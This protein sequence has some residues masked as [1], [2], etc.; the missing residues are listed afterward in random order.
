[1]TEKRSRAE[2]LCMDGTIAS[3][4]VPVFPHNPPV[5][6]WKGQYFTGG[7]R[8]HTNPAVVEYMEVDTY[9]VPSAGMDSADTEEMRDHLL[10]RVEELEEENDRL[11]PLGD[12]A[13]SYLQCYDC[14]EAD[15]EFCWHHDR[16]FTAALKALSGQQ[17]EF[18]EVE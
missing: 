7:D 17:I 11:R 2:M 10:A 9:K 1:M 14:G 12:W 6:I 5:V 16:E 13:A 3:V 18:E 15:G 4:D 8:K